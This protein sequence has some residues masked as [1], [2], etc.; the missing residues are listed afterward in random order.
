MQSEAEPEPQTTCKAGLPKESVTTPAPGKTAEPGVAA[1]YSYDQQNARLIHSEEQG[2]ILDRAY[3]STGSLKSETRTSA[4]NA[5]E[6]FY[7]YSRQGLLL[8]YTDVLGQ[9]QVNRYDNC[10]RLY[11]T[12]LGEVYSTF[13][14]DTAFGRLAKNHHHRQD[15]RQ[16]R[17][18]RRDLP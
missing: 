5:Y 7:S 8:S 6:M 10:G 13:D 16:P 15:R 12:S 2:E 14:Y 11:E 4:G 1:D 3:Y 18:N 17:E 9:E